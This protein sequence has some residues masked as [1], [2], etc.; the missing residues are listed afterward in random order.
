MRYSV[1]DIPSWPF[2]RHRW[3]SSGLLALR[4]WFFVLFFNIFFLGGLHDYITEWRT[5]GNFSLLP[6]HI[7]RALPLAERVDFSRFPVQTVL[8]HL[9]CAN[10]FAPTPPSSTT[11]RPTPLFL[12]P[13]WDF[14]VLE[15]LAHDGETGTHA[16][17]QILF[18]IMHQLQNSSSLWILTC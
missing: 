16:S 10:L 12:P 5:R 4:R 8:G 6:T 15:Y 3:S 17:R 18:G 9:Q 1:R 13:S 7:S 14:A 11:S 2:A